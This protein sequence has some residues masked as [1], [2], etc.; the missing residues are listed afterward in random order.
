MDSSFH[1]SATLWL[2]YDKACGGMTMTSFYISY[3]VLGFIFYCVFYF[4][5]NGDSDFSYPV[6]LVW[7]CY[8]LLQVLPFFFLQENRFNYLVLA[9]M[10]LPIF[11]LFSLFLGKFYGSRLKSYGQMHYIF[12]PFLSLCLGYGKVLLLLHN[13]IL[14]LIIMLLVRELKHRKYSLFVFYPA[15]ATLQAASILLLYAIREEHQTF[16]QLASVDSYLRSAFDSCGLFTACS[17]YIFLA[18]RQI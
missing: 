3:T 18:E 5:R 8:L 2:D 6:S 12:T 10:D 7:V 16:R 1:S 15:W 9:L 13:L 4:R 14:L 17:P 11:L